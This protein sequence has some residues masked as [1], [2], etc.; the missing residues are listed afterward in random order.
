MSIICPVCNE[1]KSF[2]R[3]LIFRCSFHHVSLPFGRVF[4]DERQDY[5]W[6]CREKLNPVSVSTP[7]AE[8]LRLIRQEESTPLVFE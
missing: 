2:G 1:E 7:S 6:N 3:S 5:S 8:G 4:A